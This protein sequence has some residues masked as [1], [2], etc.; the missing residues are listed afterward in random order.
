M[1]IG[2][3]L[4]PPGIAAGGSPVGSAGFSYG[5]DENQTISYGIRRQ[6]HGIMQIKLAHDI[7]AVFFDSFNADIQQLGNLFLK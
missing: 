1:K 6:G 4:R 5:M 7:G 3:T 2:G